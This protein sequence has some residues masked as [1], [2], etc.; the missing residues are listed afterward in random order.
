VVRN[1]LWDK[2]RIY[3]EQ[4]FSSIINHFRKLRALC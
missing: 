1:D 3:N 2:F 4:N